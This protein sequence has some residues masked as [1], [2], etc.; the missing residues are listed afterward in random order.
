MW[1]ILLA[2]TLVCLLLMSIRGRSGHPGLTLLRKYNYA[3]RGLQGEGR[4][5]NSLAA[6]AAAREKGYGCELDV[7]LLKDGNLAVIH[8]SALK[9]TT[10]ADGEIEDLTIDALSGYFLENTDQTIPS[11]GQVLDLIDGQVPLIIE[12]KTAGG[13]YAALCQK[14]C[15]ALDSYD[16]PFCVESFDP[17][18]IYWLRKHRPQIIRGQLARNFL[19][20]HKDT[21]FVLRFLLTNHMLNFL[22]RPDFIAYRFADRKRFSTF[23]ARRLWDIQGVSWTLTTPEQ[24]RAAVEEGWIPIFENYFP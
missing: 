20:I 22:T 11:F 21:P 8:D 4:P 18:C 2:L 15:Q 16:G 9:R 17:R 19:H 24:H 3:H 23:L 14:A 5:E 7:H 1:W 6:F 13:N 10:G 12:L